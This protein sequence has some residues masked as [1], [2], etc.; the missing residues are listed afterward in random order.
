MTKVRARGRRRSKI[1]TNLLAPA[2]KDFPLA[3]DPPIDLA[4]A[5]DAARNAL[6]KICPQPSQPV[7]FRLARRLTR[8]A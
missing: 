3:A 5:L 7:P 2:C 4:R 6:R 1:F 8:R